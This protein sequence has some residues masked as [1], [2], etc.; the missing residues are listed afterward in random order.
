MA[1][2]GYQPYDGAGCGHLCR[3]SV[4]GMCAQ[5][6]CLNHVT[7]GA[8]L[9]CE[10]D[11]NACGRAVADRLVVPLLQIMIPT[12]PFGDMTITLYCSI[13]NTEVKHGTNIHDSLRIPPK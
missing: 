7:P 4:L 3:T 11:A 9:F 6:L 12:M 1:T 8:F 5:H 13:F 2:G 10:C